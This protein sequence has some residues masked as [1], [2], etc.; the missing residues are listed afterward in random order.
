MDA[1]ITDDAVQDMPI[2][3]MHNGYELEFVLPAGVYNAEVAREV[4]QTDFVGAFAGDVAAC[5]LEV[6]TQVK[7]RRSPQMLYRRWVNKKWLMAFPIQPGM[8]LAES[9]K[10]SCDDP[11]KSHPNLPRDECERL[12]IEEV[13]SMRYG[14]KWK[15][16]TPATAEPAS[17]PYAAATPPVRPPLLVGL[18]SFFCAL[19]DGVQVLEC[20]AVPGGH[21][22]E[23]RVHDL[24]YVVP[25]DSRRDTGP[26]LE[27]LTC[28]S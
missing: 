2:L 12:A 9:V 21:H 22:G 7:R 25:P 17:M 24:R 23:A 13:R 3:L 15:T 26:L 28:M 14:G 8:N 11:Y 27:S 16:K 1:A 18:L 20:R 10:V 5:E 6:T 4:C 19:C